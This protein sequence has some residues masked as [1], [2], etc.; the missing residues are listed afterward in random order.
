MGLAV[1][2]FLNHSCDPNIWMADEVTLVARRAI[3][4]GEEVL[5]DYAMYSS[6]DWVA[7]WTCHCGAPACRGKILGTDWQLPELQARYNGHFSPFI[8]RK[9]AA[10]QLQTVPARLVKLPTV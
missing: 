3:A 10:W 2:D 6:S 9:I 8:E 5:V 4:A 1:D 7:A